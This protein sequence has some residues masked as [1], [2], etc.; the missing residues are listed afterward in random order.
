MLRTRLLPAR[1]FRAEVSAQ[2]QQGG[3]RR[4]E[5]T[6]CAVKLSKRTRMREL[7]GLCRRC[8]WRGFSKQAS[9]VFRWDFAGL[10]VDA[11]CAARRSLGGPE[12]CDGDPSLSDQKVL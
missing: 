11:T 9:M 7:C 12:A 8:G 10:S 5:L 1:S 3:R 2:S 4:D 6:A